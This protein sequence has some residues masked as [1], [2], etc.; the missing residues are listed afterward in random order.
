M[1]PFKDV[2]GSRIIFAGPNKMFTQVNKDQQRDSS[3]S[4]YSVN[5][6]YL[7]T[8]IKTS[9]IGKLRSESNSRIKISHLMEST[10]ELRLESNSRIKISHLTNSSYWGRGT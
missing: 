10:G 3:H 2:E 6:D 8:F 4:V 7:N 1:S 9:I 5:K